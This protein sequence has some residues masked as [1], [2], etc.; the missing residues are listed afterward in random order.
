M[1][2]NSFLQF[3]KHVIK[4]I[5]EEDFLRNLLFEVVYFLVLIIDDVLPLLGRRV[6]E[7]KLTDIF[8]YFAFAYPS[9]KDQ[10][11]VQLII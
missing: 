5:I 2:F 4:S 10:F 7:R 9:C 8:F 1:I 6:C 11:K 3:R